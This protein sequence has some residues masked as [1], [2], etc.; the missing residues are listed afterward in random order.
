MHLLGSGG[1]G[2]AVGQGDGA[3]AGGWMGAGRGVVM[4][5]LTTS[6]PHWKMCECAV[7]VARTREGMRQQRIKGSMRCG[8]CGGSGRVARCAQ[9]KGAGLMAGKSWHDPLIVCQKC[10][11]TG[12]IR[13]PFQ[14]WKRSLGQ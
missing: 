2:V 12:A 11:G 1:A 5:A 6:R 8:V 13:G 7:V 9:C 4:C 14:I 10:S 3:G